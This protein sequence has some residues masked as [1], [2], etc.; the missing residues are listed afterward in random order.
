ETWQKGMAAVGPPSPEI[1]S[2]SCFC[3]RAAAA[4]AAREAASMRGSSA[5]APRVTSADRPANRDSR[6]IIVPNYPLRRLEAR[7]LRGPLDAKPEDAV[8]CF[9]VKR[10]NV[11]E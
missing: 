4:S 1:F 9:A 6:M 2:R 11:H 8:N 3:K 7:D 10:A 5:P